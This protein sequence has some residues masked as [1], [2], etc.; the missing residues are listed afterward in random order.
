M[1][2]QA[3]SSMDLKL[4]ESIEIVAITDAFKA[5]ISEA[6]L[7]SLISR[8]F[9]GPVN[10][11]LLDKPTY[12]QP[13]TV[14]QAL[15]L[16]GG[17]FS[18]MIKDC[19]NS[20]ACNV[21]PKN[22]VHYLSLDDIDFVNAKNKSYIEYDDLKIIS[23]IAEKKV[24]SNSFCVGGY[25]FE[26]STEFSSS[27]KKLALVSSDLYVSHII[28]DLIA[29]GKVFFAAPVTRYNDW[30][31]I[32]EY[33]AYQSSV[34]SYF[35]DF[36]GVLVENSS[37]FDSPPWQYRPISSNLQ[38]LSAKLRDSPESSLIITTSRPASE[39]DNIGS[40]LM[41]YSIVVHSL[42]TDLPHCK[43]VL[44][45]DFSATNQYPSAIGVS[46]PRDSTQIV[47]YLDS[48]Q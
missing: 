40:F 12:N 23:R 35:C 45:N 28:F 22:L 15:E 13:E 43:R 36:D 9:D 25:S 24:I 2:E 42:V 37:K 44:I 19:D 16:I 18:F 8:H 20:F 29:S 38:Y 14:N 11:W 1:L 34:V 17:D 27:Y 21:E 47:Q 30:G 32:D 6:S 31:T 3:I 4:F 41:D 5:N 46:I 48:I 26:S 39:R 10:I 7:K 33:R